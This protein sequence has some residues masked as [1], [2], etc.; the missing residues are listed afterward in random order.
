MKPPRATDTAPRRAPRHKPQRTRVLGTFSYLLMCLIHRLPP[1]ERYGTILEK[2][3]NEYY[4]EPIT[5][6]Q[7]YVSLKRLE[8]DG[9]LKAAEATPITG[10]NYKVHLYTITPDGHTKL[11]EAIAFYQMLAKAAPKF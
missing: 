2:D 11:K 4:G 9:F 7:V 5:L 10:T 3:V 8:A 6:A 1:E